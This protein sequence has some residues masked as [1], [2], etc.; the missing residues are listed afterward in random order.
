MTLD[1][2]T[3][4]LVEELK[5]VYDAEQQLLKALPKMG[6]A[7]FSENLSEAFRLH[8]GQ[9]EKRLERLKS[10]F[11][12]LNTKPSGKRCEGMKGIMAEAE[13]LID[14]EPKADP[15]VFDAALIAAAQRAEHY[16]IASYGT[17]HAYG[18]L[19]AQPRRRSYSSRP[20]RKRPRRTK[21]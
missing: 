14:E 16:E 3:G 18:A 9:T 1:S 10:V 8:T 2:L 4:L 7:A 17:L 20:W 6:K 5:D 11:E 13:T 21:S 15:A 19:L 12:R